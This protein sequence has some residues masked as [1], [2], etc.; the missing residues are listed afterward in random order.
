LEDLVRCDSAPHLLKWRTYKVNYSCF[1]AK[2]LGL[3]RSKQSWWLAILH[4]Y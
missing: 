3:D 4:T 2:L 1:L